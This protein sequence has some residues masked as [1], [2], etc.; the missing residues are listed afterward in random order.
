IINEILKIKSLKYDYLKFID[1]KKRIFLDLEKELKEKEINKIF[2]TD[3]SLEI[4]KEDIKEIKKNFEF[5]VID[6]HPSYPPSFKKTK[7]IIRTISEDCAS[8]TLFNLMNEYI[9]KYNKH[10]KFSKERLKFL[11][12]LICATMISEFSYNKKSNFLFIKEFYPKVKIKTIYN[13]YIGKICQNLSYT[14]LFYEKDKE[15]VFDLIN[16]DKIEEFSKYNKKVKKEIDYYLKK[17]NKEKIK[18]KENLYFYYLKPKPRFSIGSIVSTTLSLKE[19]DKTFVICSDSLENSSFIKVNTRN[20]NG[21]ENTNLL[22]K[23]AIKGLKNANGG[24][25]FK[26]SAAKFLKEDLEVFKKNLIS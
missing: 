23:K 22:M 7:N 11:R 12:T 3:I 5:F 25:H 1:Y 14:I 6:H 24:G 17:F 8:F 13:S 26:A 19:K 10:Y 16:K 15:K 4:F 18:L 21:K 9:E 2:I 20:Q